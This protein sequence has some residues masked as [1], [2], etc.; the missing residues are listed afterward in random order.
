MLESEVS[1]GKGYIKMS[2]KGS[3]CSGSST[4]KGMDNKADQCNPNNDK[5]EGHQKGYQGIG[6][7]P[8]L[9][10]HGNQMNPNNPEYKK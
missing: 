6:D 5:Y 10:N 1:T 9:D 7:K 8:D 4:Q 3:C 2:G